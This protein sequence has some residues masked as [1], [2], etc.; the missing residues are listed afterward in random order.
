MTAIEKILPEYRYAQALHRTTTQDYEAADKHLLRALR[1]I[2]E[3][4][5]RLR[6]CRT[7]GDERAEN[8]ALLND[9][10][11]EISRARRSLGLDVA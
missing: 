10:I 4:S 9:L 1:A 3:S 2:R 11:L 5:E 8:G 6:E 7:I